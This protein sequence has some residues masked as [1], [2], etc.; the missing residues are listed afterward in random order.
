MWDPSLAIP[1]LLGNF[2][3]TTCPH[4]ALRPPYLSKDTA[5]LMATH[6]ADLLK[7]YFSFLSQVIT[8]FR[9]LSMESFLIS[10][11]IF[12]MQ[13]MCNSIYKHLFRAPT[14]FRPLAILIIALKSSNYYPNLKDEDLSQRDIHL[15]RV[16]HLGRGWA[17]LWP[18]TLSTIMLP[19]FTHLLEEFLYYLTML[20]SP[21][22]SCS[23]LYSLSA[24]Q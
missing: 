19:L 3:P 4:L 21:L 1:L 13:Y 18:G 20:L 5:P 7:M 14:L 15:P 12:I 24:V 8:E 6:F 10:H 11:C 2:L 23:F 16:T 9:V 17:G 22:I